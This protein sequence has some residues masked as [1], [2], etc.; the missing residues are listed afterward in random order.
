MQRRKRQVRSM[1]RWRKDHG[2]PSG[3]QISPPLTAPLV[4]GGIYVD[5]RPTGGQDGAGPSPFF[6]IL[7]QPAVAL[8]HTTAAT[9][10]SSGGTFFE[11]SPASRNGWGWC[12]QPWQVFWFPGDGTLALT[13]FGSQPSWTSNARHLAFTPQQGRPSL[14]VRLGMTGGAKCHRPVRYS[15]HVPPPLGL[16]CKAAPFHRRPSSHSAGTLR[17]ER[18][19]P[20]SYIAAGFPGPPTHE[21]HQ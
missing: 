13:R 15:V 6:M 8:S 1:P 4:G 14:A 5:H 19:D 16:T 9:H 17:R 2:C 18:R 12:G 10:R 11:K 7:H 20:P 21:R 3:P